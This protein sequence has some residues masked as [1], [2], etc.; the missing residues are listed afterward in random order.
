MSRKGTL[1]AALLLLRAV[2]LGGGDVPQ[3]REVRLL[4]T[5]DILLSRQVQSEIEHRHIFPWK[6][7]SQFFRGADWIA[8]NFEG[9][10]GSDSQCLANG[11]SPCFAV[12][13]EAVELLKT[14]GFTTLSVENNHSGD[15]G[16]AGRELTSANLLAAG[17]LPLDFEDSP[18]FLR[19]GGVTIA[20]LAFSTVP[21]A[22]G[23]VQQ[24]PSVAL[25]QKLRLA[26][27]LANLVVVSIHWGTELQDWPSQSQ[28]QQA[29]W[30][31]RHGADLILGHH[32]HVVQQPEC[33]LGKPNHV[34]DQRYPETKEG[35]I[36]E[37]HIT[38]G[39][40]RCGGISTRT[41][42]NTSIPHLVGPA[43]RV[44]TA[45]AT[46]TPSLTGDL[47]VD[48]YTLRPEPRSAS[49]PLEGL[50]ISAW[51]A[52]RLEWRSRRQKVLSLEM[53][54]LAEPTKPPLVFTLERHPS[55]LD[56]EE[57]LRPYVYAVGRSGLVAKWR[58]SALAWPLL[59]AVIDP[60]TGYVC[61]LHRADSFVT[62]KPDS[63]GT[64]I[65]AY[66]WNGFGFTGIDYPNV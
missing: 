57:G 30:L 62:L 25:A 27:H 53:D 2:A 51:K 8:G 21:A 19:F 59:D 33:V 46:C 12:P 20:V 15:L 11:K 55:P 9:A 47:V 16:N 40:L 22:D 28:R 54:E 63:T 4:F 36:A 6:E 10:F 29:E 31:V 23:R 44:Q 13:T 39:R 38:H 26:R 49:K 43:E 42:P 56:Q 24:I 41:E 35:L 18:Q 61:A 32:P 17:I 5:G 1:L 3:H 58:G 65:A 7:F 64:R 66:K 45:L 48:G 14:A 37:C 34:F 50:I 60:T 52:G